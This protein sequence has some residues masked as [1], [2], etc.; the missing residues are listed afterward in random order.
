M[1]NTR[2]WLALLLAALMVLALAACGK[3]DQPGSDGQ[4]VPG[5]EETENNNEE[6]TT[7]DTPDVPETRTVTDQAG[8]EVTVPGQIDRVAIISTVPLASVYS[9]MT[10]E[11]DTIVGLT[12]E[13]VAAL[14]PDVVF[15]NT[16]NAADA[17]AA[18]QLTQQGIPCVGF[19]TG[20]SKTGDTIAT[21]TSWATLMG[22]V[23]GQETRAQALA[24][25]GAAAVQM[26][27]ERVSA[28][29][30]PA[31]KASKSPPP[32]WIW[33]RSMPGTRRSSC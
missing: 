15:Y 10:G 16:V 3:Q 12:P 8:A 31:K 17:E 20:V 7:P 22:Q 9:M 5:Q 33:S 6:N 11:A 21:F 26:V 23:L 29:E 2:R 27:Q 4:D 32:P 24:D 25:Y 1:K 28:V 19:S 30:S 13:A 18:A 14:E